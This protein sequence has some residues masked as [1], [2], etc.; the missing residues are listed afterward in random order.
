MSVEA[1]I[2]AGIGPKAELIRRFAWIAAG[3]MALVLVGQAGWLVAKVNGAGFDG[4]AIRLDFTAFWGASR[5]ALEGRATAAFDPDQ[6]RAALMLSSDEAPGDMLWAYPP[7]W[8]LAVLPLGLMPFSV[9]WLAYS[10]LTLGAFAAAARPL[11]RPLPGGLALVLAGPAVI[12]AVTIGNNSLVS[13]AGLIGALAATQRQRWA[14]AGFLIALLTFKPQL[15]LLIPVA[16]AFGGYWRT[17]AWAA[18]GTV[19]VAAVS[20]A[21]FDI[22]YWQ[23]FL[24]AMRFMGSLMQTDLVRFERMMTWYALART[25]GAPHELALP[26]HLAIAAGAAAAMAWIWRHPVTL[27]LK[28][29]SLCLAI[30]LATPYAFHYEMTL[31]L[32]AAMFLIRDGVGATPLERVWLVALWLGPIPGLALLQHAPPVLYAAP[33]MT[34]SLA[35]CLWRARAVQ[36]K[37]A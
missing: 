14:L 6:F 32:A 37:P 1:R 22:E 7:A 17:I 4:Q 18:A 28:A 30:P 16:L 35:A 15:G 2:A 34:V 27:D 5:L 19:A 25:G 20:T 26:V 21:A 9:A 11:A 36:A 31:A 3:L 29:A 23:H 8:H 13:T 24:S 12:I 33:L 10:A